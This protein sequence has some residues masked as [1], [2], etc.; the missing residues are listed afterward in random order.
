[1]SSRHDERLREARSRAGLHGQQTEEVSSPN[2]PIQGLALERELVEAPDREFTVAARSQWNMVVHRFFRHKLAVVSLAVFVAVVLF[3]FGGGALWHY[4][5]QDFTRDYS[6]GPSLKH[7]FGT[8][9][10]SHDMFAQVLRGTQRS[11]EIALFVALVATAIGTIYGS[12]AGFFRGLSDSIMMRIVDLFLTF[13]VIAVAAILG[14]QLGAKASGWLWI[15]IVLAA[16]TWPY[17]SRVVRGVTL[18]IREKEYI[19][20]SRALGASNARII[21]RHEVPNVIGPVI[22]TVTILVATAILAETALSFIGFGVKAPDTSLGLL[23]FDGQTAVETRPWLFYFPGFFIIVI[24][25]SINFIGDG[26]RDA[27]DPTQTRV[28]A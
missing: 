15:A 5:Y 8:D 4:N 26:L 2:A 12:I 28:R 16:L 23:V 24:A 18:S 14:D 11:L 7:P 10:S 21:A 22:V 1:M 27:L 25:L 13:P 19:E 6:A 9:S 3:A 17:V 20:A